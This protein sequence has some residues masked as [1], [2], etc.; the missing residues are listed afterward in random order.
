MRRWVIGFVTWSLAAAMAPK[1]QVGTTIVP[2]PG[3]TTW[4]PGVRGIPARTTVCASVSAA[5]YGNGQGEASAGIQAAINSCPEG[6]IVQLSAGTFR[7]DNH[8]LINR[9]ITLRG[10]GPG[11]TTLR[12]TNGASEQEGLI[13][14]GPSRWPHIDV[15]TAVNLAAD[16]VQGAMSITVQNAA[17]FA[18]GQFVKLDEDD[19]NTAQWMALPPRMDG[20][21]P[22]VLASDL[23]LI[24]I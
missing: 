2:Q 23:S 16:A 3:A 9:A 21:A 5:T 1:A 4:A 13:I 6:Q 14:V 22:R 19:Y 18:P 12:K 7:L 15:T 17:G 20:S 8:V 11:Q 10:A 24:H